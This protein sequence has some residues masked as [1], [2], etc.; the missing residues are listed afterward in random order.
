MHPVLRG[1]SRH[2]HEVLAPEAA[3]CKSDPVYISCRPAFAMVVTS[4]VWLMFQAQKRTVQLEYL[5][6]LDSDS[7]KTELTV[8]GV[9]LTPPRPWLANA[10][11][12]LASV[13]SHTCVFSV[14]YGLVK[15]RLAKPSGKSRCRR[16]SSFGL[17][18]RSK[19]RRCV[20]SCLSARKTCRSGYRHFVLIIHNGSVLGRSRC[21]RPVQNQPVVWSGGPCKYELSPSGVAANSIRARL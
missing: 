10:P 1:G 19:L 7:P 5:C 20:S 14:R 13:V 18:I 8:G 15:I 6:A 4:R 2:T 3:S 9:M 21:A 12:T 16:C 11:T 17:L